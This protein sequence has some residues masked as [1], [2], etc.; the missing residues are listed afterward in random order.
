MGGRQKCNDIIALIQ[1]RWEK[2]P[3]VLIKA[4]S[5][6]DQEE[7]IDLKQEVETIKLDHVFTWVGGEEKNKE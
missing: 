1:V 4:V 3:Y 5:S 6:E 7:W 2:N